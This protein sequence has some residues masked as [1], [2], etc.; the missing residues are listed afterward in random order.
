MD[1]KDKEKA[2]K[3]ETPQDVAAAIATGIIL[4]RSGPEGS[5]TLLGGGELDEGSW[6]KSARAGCGN[7]I[8]HRLRRG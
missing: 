1:E 4:H 6:G 8:A 7:G 5:V 2:E 3:E